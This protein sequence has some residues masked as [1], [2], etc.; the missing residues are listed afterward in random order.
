MEFMR[1]C[2][3]STSSTMNINITMFYKFFLYLLLIALYIYYFGVAS[4]NRFKEESIVT[5]NQILPISSR[6]IGRNPGK[7]SERNIF[8]SE[9]FKVWPSFREIPIPKLAGKI[10]R[11]NIWPKKQVWTSRQVWRSTPTRTMRLFSTP[12]TLSNIR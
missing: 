4:F 12:N 9:I 1:Y 3:F 6:E 5:I 7:R 8:L 11:L 10:S 2:Q